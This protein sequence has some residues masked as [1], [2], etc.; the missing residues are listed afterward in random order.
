M[1]PCSRLT[2][3]VMVCSTPWLM[4]VSPASSTPKPNCSAMMV[5]SALPWLPRS[6][7]AYASR[8]LVRSE[9]THLDQLRRHAG[10]VVCNRDLVVLGADG[11][12]RSRDARFL[13]SIQGIV[14]QL[15]ERGAE[16]VVPRAPHAL[17]ELGLG[18]ELEVARERKDGALDQRG[19]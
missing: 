19:H 3:R 10:S 4:I 6:G 7:A 5:G 2:R 13:G 8:V 12:R 18:R 1:R 16:P 14:D 9:R 15:F 17:R 11:D